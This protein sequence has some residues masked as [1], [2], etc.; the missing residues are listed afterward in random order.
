MIALDRRIDAFFAR[1][2]GLSRVLPRNHLP[3]G[4]PSVMANLRL[5]HQLRRA[6]FLA[7]ADQ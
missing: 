2:P 1:Y 3:A 4:G 6:R 5:L 7:S